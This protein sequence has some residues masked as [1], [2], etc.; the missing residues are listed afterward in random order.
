MSVFSE[1]ISLMQKAAADKNVFYFVSIDGADEQNT[2]VIVEFAGMSN[3]DHAMWFGK[4]MSLLLQMND[5]DGYSE[6]PN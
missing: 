5:F 3:L 4:Y 1:D 6:L 2:K